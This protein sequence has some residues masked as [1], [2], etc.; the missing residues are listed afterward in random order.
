MT[1]K[2]IFDVERFIAQQSYKIIQSLANDSDE[3]NKN[4]SVFFSG[5]ARVIV[6]LCEEAQL[7]WELTTKACLK[8]IRIKN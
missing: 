1:T 3:K 7:K 5:E 2:E 6:A 4:H 8:K